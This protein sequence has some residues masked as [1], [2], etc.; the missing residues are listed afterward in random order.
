VNDTVSFTNRKEKDN[1]MKLI[2]LSLIT[3][4][5]Y[6]IAAIAGLVS[7][8]PIDALIAVVKSILVG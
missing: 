3:L 4:V 7:S 5:A 8:A 2:T 6:G 1:H